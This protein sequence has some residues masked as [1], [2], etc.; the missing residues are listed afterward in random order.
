MKKNH[1]KTILLYVVVLALVLVA[2][3]FLFQGQKNDKLV[4]ADVVQYFEADRIESFVINE[5]YY[6][7]LRSSRPTRTAISL[8]TTRANG[9]WRS[10]PTS[11]SPW[12][13][14]RNTATITWRTM[15]TSEPTISSLHPPLGGSASCPA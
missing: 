7:T 10:A 15:P 9:S 14:L 8:S 13:Y 2:V 6:I 5:S 1:L 12:V 4:L 3:R 11:C